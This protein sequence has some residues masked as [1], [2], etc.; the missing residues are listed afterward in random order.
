MIPA[1]VSTSDMILFPLRK[2]ESPQNQDVIAAINALPLTTLFIPSLL[3]QY[4]L[5]ITI[6][7][8]KNKLNQ[9]RRPRRRWRQTA[10]DRN[11]NS[12]R[13]DIQSSQCSSPNPF[14]HNTSFSRPRRRSTNF[15]IW[16]SNGKTAAMPKK[17]APLKKPPEKMSQRALGWVEAGGGDRKQEAE[18]KQG[19]E[20]FISLLNY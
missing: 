16:H 1:A 5:Y 2:P 14:H 6:N 10:Q 20:R 12:D 11:R 7:N 8:N 15:H 9:T 17:S 13:R 18:S 3:T 19:R 4:Y